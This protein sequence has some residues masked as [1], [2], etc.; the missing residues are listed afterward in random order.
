MGIYQLLTSIWIYLKHDH[1]LI[2]QMYCKY[3]WI[4][5][6]TKMFE[7]Y[8]THHFCQSVDI[9]HKPCV[10]LRISNLKSVFTETRVKNTVAAYWLFCG[11]RMDPNF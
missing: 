9:K 5:Q 4:E 8:S 10:T 2:L 6:S 1:A 11:K 3:R 7:Y